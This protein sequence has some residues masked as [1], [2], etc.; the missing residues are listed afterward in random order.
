MKVIE[1]QNV[2]TGTRTL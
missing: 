1:V 2:G